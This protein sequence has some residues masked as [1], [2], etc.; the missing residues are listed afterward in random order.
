MEL[1]HIGYAQGFLEQSIKFLVC[2]W[3][4]IY[5]TDF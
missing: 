5:L 3:Y 2:I 4:L 1:P